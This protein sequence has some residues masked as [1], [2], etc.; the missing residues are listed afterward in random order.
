MSSNKSKKRTRIKGVYRMERAVQVQVIKPGQKKPRT[1]L[2]N[3]Y[4]EDEEAPELAS[5][6]APLQIQ[7]AVIATPE[8]DQTTESASTNTTTG[9]VT[10]CIIY[11]GAFVW[12][13]LK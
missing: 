7:P 12:P 4:D 11:L 10:I 6:M 13:F 5:I 3:I 8:P 9:N 2:W 1:E